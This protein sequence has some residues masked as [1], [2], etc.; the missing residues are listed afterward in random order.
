[1]TNPNNSLL[2]V[3][4]SSFG[5]VAQLD[6]SEGVPFSFLRGGGG[7]EQHPFIRQLTEQ[8]RNTDGTLAVLMIVFALFCFIW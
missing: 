1:M 6:G 7:A 8:R 4:S 5:V 3:D 2:L